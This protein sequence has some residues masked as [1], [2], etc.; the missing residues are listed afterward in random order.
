MSCCGKKCKICDFTVGF[1]G[2]PTRCSDFLVGWTRYVSKGFQE[3]FDFSSLCNCGRNG[4]RETSN[5]LGCLSPEEN[6]Q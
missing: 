5:C 4:T 2:R 3:E 6:N 1:E